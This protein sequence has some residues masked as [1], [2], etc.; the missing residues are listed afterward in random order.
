MKKGFLFLLV[1]LMTMYCCGCDPTPQPE[2]EKIM[3]IITE[4]EHHP[5]KSLLGNPAFTTINFKDGRVVNFYGTYLGDIFQKSKCITIFYNSEWSIT[6]VEE[7]D[8]T[9]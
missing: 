3:G 1:I 5:R 9:E 7:C 4:I 2:P 8:S 6:R